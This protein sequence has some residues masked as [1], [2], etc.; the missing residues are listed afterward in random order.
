IPGN[1]WLYSV[2]SSAVQLET[3][4]PI[5]VGGVS[6]TNSAIQAGVPLRLAMKDSYLYT[7]TFLQGL[8]VVD[9]NQV[10]SEYQQASPTEFG[11]AMSTDGEGFA[12]DAVINTI[13]LTLASG[14]NATMF[15]LKADDFATSGAQGTA[16]TQTLLVATGQVPFIMADPT[17]SSSSAILYPATSN[18]GLSQAPMSLAGNPAEQLV[19]GQA[20]ALGTISVTDSSGNTTNKH[21]AVVV[22]SGI[23]SSGGALVPVLAVV[24]VSQTYSP[25]SPFSPSLIGL[26][27]LST[28][29]FDVVLNGSV[30][31]VSTGTNVLMVNLANPSQPTYAGQITGDFGDY[32]ALA[33][34]NTLLGDT[35][36]TTSTG[37]QTADLTGN[38]PPPNPNLGRCAKKHNQNVA[39]CPIDL[40]NGNVYVGQS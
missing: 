27:Q 23:V 8:Q 2:P 35:A 25:G 31:L 18:G 21:V 24:D 19:T 7:F 15:G 39:G 38:L 40:T 34:S 6:V 12:T 16:A 3:Q 5:R 4:P 37:V 11:T 20:V 17:L 36:N 29:G 14:G 9:L 22:G 28:E 32:L 33:N 30:A 26:L 1:V 13:P 10:I